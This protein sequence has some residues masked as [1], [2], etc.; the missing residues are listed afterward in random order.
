MSY[1]GA[2]SALYGGAIDNCKLTGLDSYSSGQVFD[3][4][5][6]IED[7]NTTSIIS[8]EPFRIC[9]CENNLPN[10]HETHILHAVHIYPGATFHAFVVA[11]G[12]RAGTAPSTVRSIINEDTTYPSNLADNQYLQKTN[13]T[14]TKLKYTVFSL[15]EHVNMTLQVEDRWDMFPEIYF[16]WCIWSTYFSKSKPNLPTWI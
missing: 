3:N 16:W 8:S 2:G 9:H 7:D 6:N 1:G 11:V 5:V 4:I 15:S 13:N 10:C 14:C 12:Q